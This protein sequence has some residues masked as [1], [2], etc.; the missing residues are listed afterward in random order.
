[1]KLIN[2]DGVYY[3]VSTTETKVEVSKES[4]QKEMDEIKETVD[5]LL[6]VLLEKESILSQM[7]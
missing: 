4:L 5:Q 7:K 2:E 6:S 1:M 3:L